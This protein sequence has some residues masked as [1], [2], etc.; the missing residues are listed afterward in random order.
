MPPQPHPA[1]SGL[2]PHLRELRDGVRALLSL[3]DD[4]AVIIRQFTYTEPGHPPLETV[5]TVLA[6]DGEAHRWTLHR[7]ADQITEHDLR[8]AL[9]PPPAELTPTSRTGLDAT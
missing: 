3:D 6:M 5:V 1:T 8:A 9:A 4:T 2:C 7:P